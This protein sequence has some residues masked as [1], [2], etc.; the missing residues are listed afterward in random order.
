M[1]F[2]NKF[3]HRVVIV[4]ISLSDFKGLKKQLRTIPV[5]YGDTISIQ[6][7]K[8]EHLRISV[9]LKDKNVSK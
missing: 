6:T 5:G 4:E 8:G 1:N 9:R 7:S 3:F 2:L